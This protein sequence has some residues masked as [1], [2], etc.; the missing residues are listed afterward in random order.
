MATGRA[1][2]RAAR[3]SSGF[4]AGTTRRWAAPSP[5]NPPFWLTV[6]LLAA[7]LSLDSADRST[8]SA[9]EPQLQQQFH[10][11]AA[12]F[13]WLATVTALVGLVTTFP[14]GILADRIHRT[15]LLGVCTTIWALAEAASAIAPSFTVLLVSRFFLGAVLAA[16][17]AVISL[18]GDYYP[19][20]ERART[21]G[22]ILAGELAGTAFGYMASGQVGIATSWRWADALLAAIGGVLAIL[23]WRLREPGRG[24]QHREEAGFTTSSQELDQ[25]ED[26]LEREVREQHIP[27]P[28][29]IVPERDPRA[30]P[31]GQVVRYVL[32]VRSNLV[33][34]VASTLSYLFLA[35]VQTFAF[36]FA[37]QHLHLSSAGS[38][39]VLLIVGAGAVVGVLITGRLADRMIARGRLD[40]RPL[41]AAIALG[42]AALCFVP[43]FLVPT[44]WVAIP[45]LTVGAVGLGGSNPVLDSARLDV[46]HHNA[47]GRTEGI[48]SAL[49]LTGYALA[50][51]IVSTLSVTLGI[52]WAF[53]VLTAALA[54][55]AVVMLTALRYYRY[56]VSAAMAA[57]EPDS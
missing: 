24:T 37:G 38:T 39:V 33:L 36:A 43:G 14:I 27:A 57:T 11:G 35:G 32:K 10:I 28:P 2:A 19:V 54:L 52:A 9:V 46:I 34:I 16:I 13:G 22:Y 31:A 50:P 29:Q 25:R 48:R 3:S 15:R 51:L 42:G 7:V 44:L 30:M 8:L 56:D 4:M 53:T 45:L 17:P 5:R 6:V 18:A 49:R 55:A 1:V 21:F 20:A 40:A 23:V 41:V 47:W 12:G 26:E